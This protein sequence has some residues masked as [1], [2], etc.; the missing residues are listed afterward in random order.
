MKCSLQQAGVTAAC[1]AV[2]PVESRFCRWPLQSSDRADSDTVDRTQEFLSEM[3]GVR[4]M[5]ARP[6]C[7]QCQATALV[8]RSTAGR[9]LDR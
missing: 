5:V 1:N 3:L 6:C 4:R 7:P 2:H 9:V 8:Q